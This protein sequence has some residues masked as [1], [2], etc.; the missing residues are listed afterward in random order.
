[1]TTRLR[2]FPL[3]AVLFPGAVLNLHVFEARYKQLIDE[4]LQSGEGFGVVLIREGQEAGDPAVEP[5]DVGSVAEIQEVTPLP[6]GRFY[7]TT[8]GR[9]RFH[10][11]EIVSREPY[12][13]VEADLIDDDDR[14]AAQTEDLREA[15]RD[16]FLEYLQ[17]IV[18]L[19]GSDQSPDLPADARGAS[20]IIAD[21]L[22]I[23]DE[24]KQKLLELDDTGER[25]RVELGF[26]ERLLPQ[27]RAMIE[28]RAEERERRGGEGEHDP[29]RAEQ[30]KFFGKY[31]S[32]N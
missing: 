10:I 19:G 1:M 25:L 11:R 29:Q 7:V 32:T 23:S 15:V 5:H 27:L 13:L 24:I 17:L 14:T 6:F 18:E 21:A 20:F 3:N 30:E 26:L 12:L 4:C 31:F 22:Q 2:L 16:K 28:R 9:S 8:V